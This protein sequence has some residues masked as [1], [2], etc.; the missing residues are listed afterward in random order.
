MSWPTGSCCE[1]SVKR[2]LLPVE[3][4]ARG[5]GRTVIAA[6]RDPVAIDTELLIEAGL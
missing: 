6:E 1:N 3:P 4:P 5:I 2:R